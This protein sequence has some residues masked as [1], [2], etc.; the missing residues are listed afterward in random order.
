MR[1]VIH[2]G[3]HK[4]ASTYLQRHIFPQL[5]DQTVTYNPPDIFYFIN[6]IFTLDIKEKNQIQKAKETADKYKKYNDSK[7]LFISSEAISQLVFKQNYH[8]HLRI[9][10]EIFGEAEIILF[11]REQSSWL[12]SCYKESIKHHF[13][14]D[15]SDFLNYDG[16]EFK[17][18]DNRLNAAGLL[19]IDIHKSN[20]AN[21]IRTTESL[22]PSIH[23]F[24][25]EDFQKNNLKETNKIL[26]LL[27]HPSL[28]KTPKALSNPGLSKPSIDTLI[29]YHR[30]LETL[31]LTKKTYLNK[32]NKERSQVLSHDYFWMPKKPTVFI[33]A[34]RSLYKEPMR[35]LR[36]VSIYTILKQMDKNFPER[37]KYSLLT[38]E[39]KRKL[40]SIHATSNLELE[41]LTRHPLPPNYHSKINEAKKQGD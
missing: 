30:T 24:F 41:L 1:T 28:K 3:L 7:T 4:T 20:W 10:K 33:R 18:S 6:S 40:K 32:Y 11:L 36:R 14:Q 22:F 21:L 34:L 39:M 8:E 12:E 5:D 26:S 13:Y 15:I 38:E 27:G 25:Y 29:K 16:L 31:G 35:L 9:L 17:R 2:I 19:N 23:V 37:R